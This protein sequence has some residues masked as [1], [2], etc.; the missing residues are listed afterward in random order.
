M[1]PAGHQQ[2][3]VVKSVP[4]LSHMH[5]ARVGTLRL[6]LYEKAILG[7]I[8]RASKAQA[9]TVLYCSWAT[10]RMPYK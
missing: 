9:E 3:R 10:S 4:E 5:P 6:P 8:V 7:C 2:D 1:C